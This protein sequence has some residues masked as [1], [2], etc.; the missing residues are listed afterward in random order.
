MKI[1]TP[2]R[3]R[4]T[5]SL[6]Q[7]TVLCMGLLLMISAP[8][9]SADPAKGIEQ[10]AA[11][12]APATPATKKAESK[13]AA[14]NLLDGNHPAPG[15]ESLAQRLNGLRGRSDQEAVAFGATGFGQRLDR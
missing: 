5:L 2:A 10:K 7:T 1:S 9:A 6:F 11:A 3:L 14:A 4:F 15:S 13:P 12:V 8:S